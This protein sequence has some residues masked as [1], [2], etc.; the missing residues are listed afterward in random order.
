MLRSCSRSSCRSHNE[1]VN[2]SIQSIR[3]CCCCCY[4]CCCPCRH[5]P[6]RLCLFISGFPSLVGA[7]QF[8]FR[9][10]QTL[11]PAAALRSLCCSGDTGAVCSCSNCS[12]CAAR[13]RQ[14]AKQ[15]RGRGQSRV[16]GSQSTAAA[17][18]KTVAAAAAAAAADWE[19][20]NE[21]A[22]AADD[23]RCCRVPFVLRRRRSKLPQERLEAELQQ[24]LLLLHGIPFC[25]LPLQLHACCPDVTDTLQ[26]LLVYPCCG[27]GT[28]KQGR[29]SSSGRALTRVP[30]QV[31]V[32]SGPAISL[33]LRCPGL[34]VGSFTKSSSSRDS[35]SSKSSSG[36]NCCFGDAAVPDLRALTSGNSSIRAAGALC[37]AVSAAAGAAIAGC[38]ATGGAKT[39]AAATCAAAG[40]TCALCLSS[41]QDK[42]R[43]LS[44]PQ[45]G[46]YVHL[47]CA[48]RFA[49]QQESEARK[50]Q[51]LAE[52]ASKAPDGATQA[53]ATDDDDDEH[54][55]LVPAYW[56]CC[57]C[58][59]R[60]F[61]GFILNHLF[62]R[63]SRSPSQTE[64]AAAV[65]A[66][67]ATSTVDNETAACVGQIPY[68]GSVTEPSRAAVAAGAAE[69]AESTPSNAAAAATCQSAGDPPAKR[70]ASQAMAGCAGAGAAAAAAVVEGA[71]FKRCREEN[72]S[73]SQKEGVPPPASLSAGASICTSNSNGERSSLL[74]IPPLL[75]R[76]RLQ[77]SQSQPNK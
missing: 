75:E 50:Q 76:L 30:P 73:F 5:R 15:R 7:L 40:D 29:S 63:R 43:A 16:R 28:R 68:D 67:Q 53:A 21:Q 35:S 20:L 49:L 9:W 46:V 64:A 66:A 55:R 69:A 45:C 10:Q 59:R 8:E 70:K 22:A 23:S 48:G 38:A 33:S 34:R 39:P 31:T 56:W 3:C 54:Y 1:C 14:I 41:F 2:P 42:D 17:A 47:T 74:F 13:R 32:S 12:S 37:P 62:E 4:G 11:V 71:H 65:A 77:S 58:S 36:C 27:G 57:S 25:N 24:A 6:W 51:Q 72:A 44:C 52:T 60:V 18:P 19:L 61:W 26:D